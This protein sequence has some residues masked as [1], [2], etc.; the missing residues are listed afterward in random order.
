MK[1]PEYVLSE[2]H[3]IVMPIGHEDIT[4][5]AGTFVKPIDKYYVPA[6]IRNERPGI[7]I[8]PWEVFCYSRYGIYPIPKSKI[9]ERT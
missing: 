1:V 5:P 2:D 7:Y 6:H 9:R 4:I 8:A 3:R